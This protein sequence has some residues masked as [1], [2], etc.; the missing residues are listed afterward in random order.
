MKFVCITI[1]YG[2]LFTFRFVRI[3]ERIDYTA[4]ERWR[5]YMVEIIHG[6]SNFFF[7]LR[8]DKYKHKDLKEKIEQADFKLYDESTASQLDYGDGEVDQYHRLRNYFM[9]YVEQKLF[10][11]QTNEE[12]F[13]RF[14]KNF[15]K[16]F[17]LTSDGVDYPFSIASVDIIL[18]PFSIVFLVIRTK[19]SENSTV[20]K[21]EE[22]IQRFRTL[23]K[24]QQ[25]TGKENNTLLGDSTEHFI[26]TELIAELPFLF[27]KQQ[28]KR[29]SNSF[30]NFQDKKMIV[31]NF[32]T[33][34]KEHDDENL[35]HLNEGHGSH[36]YNELI[37][38]F[39]AV[40]YIEA[41]LETH[42]FERYDKHL[43]YIQAQETG[44]ITTFFREED[45]TWKFFKNYFNSAYYYQLIIHYFQSITLLTLSNEYAQ[46]EWKKDQSYVRDL[47]KKISLFDAR[48]RYT[49]ISTYKEENELTRFLRRT[50]E[51][52]DKYDETIHSLNQLF[53]SQ[54]QIADLKQN[55]LLFFLTM[56]TVITGVFGM[57]LV[58]EYWKNGISLKEI[59]DYSSMEYFVLIISM[60]SVGF[61][62]VLTTIRLID[63]I[64]EK[65]REFKKSKM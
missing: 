29:Y 6:Y 52:N 8:L 46:V 63:I 55:N 47:M 51:I 18:C 30:D 32:I 33:F 38:P 9:P 60:V 57:N 15:L 62:I 53:T 20:S 42:K 13:L 10:E 34:E 49:E 43:N 24:K 1:S 48:Y 23:E 54:E 65:V 2:F 22:F 25:F 44:T 17:Q 7:P 12:C 45:E 35:F 28:N 56:S 59:G 3:S 61:A 4:L 16:D 40:E 27:R 31:N 26:Q 64:N 37:K 58:I 5:A 19:H 14:S 39:V 21:T 11:N 36:R 41:Y 50:L